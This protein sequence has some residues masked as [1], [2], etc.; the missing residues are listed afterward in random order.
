MAIGAALRSLN[1]KNH[2]DYSVSDG[3]CEL[4][5][6]LA[7]NRVCKGYFENL[8]INSKPPVS[9]ARSAALVGKGEDR[10]NKFIKN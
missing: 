2:A 3:L 6:T 5:Q 10:K 8:S 4:L 1:D 7:A 9:V